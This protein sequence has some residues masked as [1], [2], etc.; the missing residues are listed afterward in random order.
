MEASRLLIEPGEFMQLKS[1]VRDGERNLRV[2]KNDSFYI[3]AE[4]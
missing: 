2:E 3:E 1:F 4:K